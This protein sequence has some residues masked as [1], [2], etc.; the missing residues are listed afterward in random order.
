MSSWTLAP[1]PNVTPMLDLSAK[2]PP[3]RPVRLGP[4]DVIVERRPDGALMLRSPHALA[5][6]P[7]K[8]TRRLEFWADRAPDR[9][10]FAQRAP[11][12]GWRTVSYAQALQA[13]RRIGG[14]LL[15]RDLSADRPIMILSGN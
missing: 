7:D 2:T 13:A 9:T 4:A 3:I 1:L 11:G 15:R 10:L 14:A 6:Y 5:D 12:G 8:L